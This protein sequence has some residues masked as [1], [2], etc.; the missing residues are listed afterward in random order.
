MKIFKKDFEKQLQ[1][2]PYIMKIQKVVKYV[3]YQM[4][5]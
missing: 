5:Q 4:D 2:K 3:S 1:Q